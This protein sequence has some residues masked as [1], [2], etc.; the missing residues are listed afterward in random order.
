MSLKTL[1]SN[2]Y[3]FREGLIS[4]LPGW[5]GSA[6]YDVNA[7]IVDPDLEALKKLTPEQRKAMLVPVLT[8]RFHVQVHRETKIR[9]E[10]ELVIMKD[11]PKFKESPRAIT[12]PDPAKPPAG[13]HARQLLDERQR[14]HRDR[15]AS[16]HT[17]AS[18]VDAV[19]PHR[20]R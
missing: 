19:G 16:L 9:P 6:R 8:G 17:D 4:G 14:D 2:A 7:K 10:Y 12:D 15:R 20:D 13:P 18:A 11:G 1:L 3:D 5:A